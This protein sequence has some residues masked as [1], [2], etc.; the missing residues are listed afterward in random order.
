MTDDPPP[1]PDADPG[2]DSG[3]APAA[4]PSRVRKRGGRLM[5]FDLGAIRRALLRLTESADA[6]ATDW[7][8]S[9]LEALQAELR[10]RDEKILSTAEIHRLMYE[11]IVASG[12]AQLAERWFQYAARKQRLRARI[13]AAPP[14]LPG[15][16]PD[17]DR[18][19]RPV[20]FQRGEWRDRLIA[21]GVAAEAAEALSRDL[22][23]AVL[24]IDADVLT[25]GVVAALARSL[26]LTRGITALPADLPLPGVTPAEL[27]QAYAAGDSA[28]V[29]AA[30][31]G[32][33]A[34][35]P[36]PAPGLP[37]AGRETWALERFYPE[38]VRFFHRL[39]YWRLGLS[40]HPWG[41]WAL[42]VDAHRVA[43]EASRQPSPEAAGL[44]LAQI[45]TGLCRYTAETVVAQG[46]G[47][48]IQRSQAQETLRQAMLRAFAIALAALLS[49]QRRVAGDGLSSRPP[50]RLVLRLGTPQ[51]VVA[52]EA[53]LKQML[54]LGLERYAGGLEL[55]APP[56]ALSRL[57]FQKSL[58]A[59]WHAGMP[60]RLTAARPAERFCLAPV[61]IRLSA[62]LPADG[63]AQPGG[64]A[65]VDWAHEFFDTNADDLMWAL[66]AHRRHL[67]GVLPPAGLGGAALAGNRFTQWAHAL[68]VLPYLQAQMHWQL[69]VAPL[70]LPDPLTGGGWDTGLWDKLL[71]LPER[72]AGWQGLAASAETARAK[73]R[74]FSAVLWPEDC[75]GFGAG[76]PSRPAGSAGFN[77][78]A[79]E[80][81]PGLL[82]RYGERAARIDQL[83]P[84]NLIAHE[85]DARM[86]LEDG[87]TVLEALTQAWPEAHVR[88]LSP[89]MAAQE[90]GV[91][92]GRPRF[93]RLYD[94]EPLRLALVQ[95]TAAP[96]L[97]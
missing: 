53:L 21:A 83:S 52:D 8:Q 39:G 44:R 75:T 37:A 78:S 69:P 32:S 47:E 90:Q 77:D 67:N 40:D 79:L 58:F 68:G 91:D 66:E 93:G 34:A 9:W 5:P 41:P 14:R 56:R 96:R 73:Q 74:R 55:E 85:V 7:V 82:K 84:L 59:A 4:G 38:E 26:C 33:D 71:T 13:A 50:G 92:G 89:A 20:A 86:A 3:A 88:V 72:L 18:G 17:R 42:R 11:I 61:G 48:F 94:L 80:S 24:N 6:R 43:V 2:A 15:L 29:P 49:E 19:D 31:V 30:A 22:A 23:Q 65:A 35:Q 51:H 36:P 54:D 62:D 46:V 28:T 27:D 70:G 97:F 16:E 87:R 64:P 57:M 63:R 10:R 81:L 95:Q 45:L 12:Q 1:T 76:S 25:V 60:V